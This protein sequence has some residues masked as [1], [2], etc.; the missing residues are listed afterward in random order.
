MRRIH[1]RLFA[2]FFS[3]AV[4]CVGSPALAQDILLDADV[5][6][7]LQD[8]KLTGCQVAFSVARN[9]HE[10]NNGKPSVVNGLVML[11]VH[12]DKLALRIGVTSDLEKFRPPARASFYA[13][14]R[15]NSDAL[16]SSSAASDPDFRLFVFGFSD[17]TSAVFE[18]FVKTGSIGIIYGW[19][20]S[21]IDA[22]LT[23]D[24]SQ[25]ADAH[26]E[27]SECLLALTDQN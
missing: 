9:D 8:G 12:S 17:S 25:S 27:W 19:E 7:L 5:Y 21:S 22:R 26:R 24:L 3:C 4:W 16:L 13:N 11:M 23:L 20:K 15:S 6:P 2:S 14:F 18:S 1:R 10:F